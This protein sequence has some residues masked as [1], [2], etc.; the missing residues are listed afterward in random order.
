MGIHVTGITFFEFK[1]RLTAY[2]H[3]T[4]TKDHLA[5]DIV[6]VAAMVD[7]NVHIKYCVSEENATLKPLRK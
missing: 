2:K 1:E 5:G 4:D 3:L 6:S 7:Q